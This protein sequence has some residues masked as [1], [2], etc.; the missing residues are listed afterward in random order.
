MDNILQIDKSILKQNGVSLTEYFFMMILIY[1]PGIDIS[2]DCSNVLSYGFIE[3]N[4]TGYVLT[5]KGFDFLK[6]CE[7]QTVDKK[8]NLKSLEEL[9]KKMRELY[10]EGKKDGTAKYWRD[11]IQNVVRKLNNFFK[12]Y[13]YYDEELILEATD[14]YV[15]S[16]GNN[17]QLMRILPYFI[18]KENESDLLTILENMDSVKEDS[19]NELWQTSLI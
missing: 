19:N 17:N 4:D 9:A 16:F 12:L 2:Y 7:I 3:E 6:Q 10:P 18:L 11:N 1:Q 14:K 5:N 15:K 13:G 8:I